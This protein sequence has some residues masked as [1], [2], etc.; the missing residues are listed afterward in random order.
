MARKSISG[1]EELAQAIRSRRIDLDLTIEE[2]AQRA[3]VGTKTWSRYEAGEPIRADKCAG[4]C[5]AMEWRSLPGGV[6]DP[7]RENYL[8]DLKKHK[9]W[10]TFFAEYY[11][12][13]A[14]ASFAVGSDVLLYHLDEELSAMSELPRGSHIGQLSFSIFKDILPKQFLM[15][16]DY[17]FLY[18]MKTVLIGLRTWIGANTFSKAHTVL[19][20][21]I[22]YLCIEESYFL[23]E[24]NLVEMTESFGDW[25]DWI[26]ELFEDQDLTTFLYEDWYVEDFCPYH[27]DHW[28]ERQFWCSEEKQDEED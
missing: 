25:D 22:I 23:Q 10:S 20:E 17:D 26:Y 28:M 7:D 27:F 4:V 12:E 9:A 6:D 19:E 2:A 18:R 1:G 13:H 14:A 11:G 8:K 16:Y 21:L 5:R 3:G 15:S 24:E